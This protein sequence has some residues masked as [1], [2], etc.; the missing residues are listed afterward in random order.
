MKAR[1]H[2]GLIE[3]LYWTAVTGALFGLTM[4]EWGAIGS[5]SIVGIWLFGTMGVRRY[6]GIDAAMFYSMVCTFCLS[7]IGLF[8]LRKELWGVRNIPVFDL[9]ILAATV[10]IIAGSIMT[11]IAAILSGGG[12]WIGRLA[13]RRVIA[14]ESGGSRSD[15]GRTQFGTPEQL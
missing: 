11:G 12:W 9:F 8:W 14:D 4:R 5:L 1:V 15:F 2:F 13:R 10:A 6:W 3:L 7:L